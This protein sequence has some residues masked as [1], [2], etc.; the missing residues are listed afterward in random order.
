MKLRA[1]LNATT[2][3]MLVAIARTN[4]WAVKSATSKAALVDLLAARLPPRVKDAAFLAALDDDDRAALHALA[5]ALQPVAL[6][7]FDR[8]YGP[9]RATARSREADPR[10]LARHPISTAERIL[11]AGLVYGAPDAQTG[12]P[13]IVVPSEWRERF[14]SLAPTPARDAPGAIAAPLDVS[15]ALA[16]FLAALQSAPP[17][18]AHGRWLPP[19]FVGYLARLF[20]LPT[21]DRPRERAA[22][23]LAFLRYAA[24]T[25]GLLTVLDERLLPAP[26][27]PAWLARPAAERVA[28]LWQRCILDPASAERWTTFHLPAYRL[29]Q[30]GAFLR[31][32]VER[33]G[34][35]TLADEAGDEGRLAWH[36]L[37]DLT[38]AARLDDLLPFWE[39]EEQP[40]LGRDLAWQILAAPLAWLGVVNV[41]EAPGAA[42]RLTARGDWLLGRGEPPP[43]VSAEPLRL[44]DD[45][46]LYL[47][48]AADLPALLSLAE[49]AELVS[50]PAPDAPDADGPR[51]RGAQTPLPH[52]E[53]T[54]ASVARPI[55]RG[56]RIEDLFTLL[57]RH[58]APLA[59]PD[60]QERLHRWAAA[61]APY[62]IRPAWLLTAPTGDHLDRAL[63]RRSVRRHIRRRLDLTTAEVSPADAAALANT[64]RQ[65]GLP[66]TAAAPPADRA[67]LATPPL[68]SGDALW[69][70][71]AFYVHT[72]VARRLGGVA[73]PAVVEDTLAARLGPLE[74]G[75][76]QLAAERLA[77]QLERALAA[78]DPFSQPLPQERL[79]ARLSS[80]IQ[81]SETL[82][83]TYW[84]AN[85]PLP[86]TRRVQPR[87]I[88]WRGDTA[89]LV[90]YCHRRLAELTFR[91]DRIVELDEALT[92]SPSRS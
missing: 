44:A 22:P 84:T 50:A 1:C 42:W 86:V 36:T 81:S 74:I 51:P 43:S 13:C 72:Y 59:P 45:G 90:A 24:E 88:E 87:R 52:F 7:D 63:R 12:R 92:S 65:R 49:W 75:Q 29:R 46:A 4:G 15:L 25:L 55:A 79:L 89:Y 66:V 57:T 39:L 71:T 5:N 48:P 62:T 47:P 33:V 30:P 70:L 6:H 17:R 27:A 56:A 19:R 3:A 8:V 2:W 82:S 32:V 35:V 67:A 85:R 77:A 16:V 58:A 38:P 28:D 10:R 78:L 14:A 64:L 54:P 68:P 83:M 53:L 60:L 73:P 34:A 20:H 41:A 26:A 31:R 76:A 80:A 37:D 21:E 9:I 11:Y 23:Y 18:L 69:S 91:L 61:R 40:D